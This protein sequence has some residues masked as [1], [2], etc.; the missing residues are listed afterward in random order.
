MCSH[1]DVVLCVETV[2]EARQS[3]QESICSGSLQETAVTFKS[4]FPFKEPRAGSGSDRWTGFPLMNLIRLNNFW[5]KIDPPSQLRFW[6]CNCLLSSSSLWVE[7][8]ADMF[9]VK[10]LL[11]N[12]PD[13]LEECLDNK[14]CNESN[15]WFLSDWPSVTQRSFGLSLWRHR[16]R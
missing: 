7:P 15:I 10:R 5:P 6:W 12:K 14:S 2:D 16:S 3:V 1:L 4:Y 11:C 9:L 13:S 8:E